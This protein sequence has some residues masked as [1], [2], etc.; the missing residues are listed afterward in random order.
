MF[1]NTEA[2]QRV[3]TSVVFNPSATCT[4]EAPTAIQS[5]YFEVFVEGQSASA[6]ASANCSR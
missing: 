6:L 4:I 3:F 1:R 2:L 5:R